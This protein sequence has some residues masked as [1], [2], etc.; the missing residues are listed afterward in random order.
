[1]NTGQK[2]IIRAVLAMFRSLCY[3]SHSF[4]DKQM[5]PAHRG[6]PSLADMDQGS[7]KKY[8]CKG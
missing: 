1:M 7:G 2:I 8:G 5:V 3:T 4:I 6:L